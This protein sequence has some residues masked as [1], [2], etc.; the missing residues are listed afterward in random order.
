[1]FKSENGVYILKTKQKYVKLKEPK[2]DEIVTVDIGFHYYKMNNIEGY[3][4]RSLG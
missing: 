1:M 3:Y 2:R 4:V